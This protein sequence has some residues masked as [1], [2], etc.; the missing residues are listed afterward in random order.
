MMGKSNKIEP[1]L[2][3]HG[4]S[5]ERRIPKD[6]PLRKVKELIDFTFVR[7]DVECLYGKNGNE[8]IDPSVILKLMFLLFYENIKSERALASQLPLRLDWLWFCDYDIDDTTPNHSVIS[9]ARRRWGPDVFAR[10]FENVLFQCIEA[11]LVDGRTIYIDSSTIAA[12]AS[13]EKLRPKFELFGK[14]LYQQLDSQI[15]K[16]PKL[17]A[18]RP[19]TKVTQVDPDAR[20]YTKNG[21]TILGYKEHRVIDDSNGIITAT[22]TTSANLHDDKVFSGAIEE[23]IEN[24]GIKPGKAV[25]DKAYG[26]AANYIYLHDN[27]ILPCI[28]H[29]NFDVNKRGKISRSEFTYN[30]HKDCYICPAGQQLHRYDH[31]KPYRSNSYRYRAKFDICRQCRFADRCVSSKTNGRQVVR[32]IDDEYVE[33]AD[34]CLSKH[35]RRRLL[36]RR[37]YKA[38]G[39]FADASNNHGYKRARWRGIA[40]VQIQNLMIAAVQNIRKLLGY[41]GC[42]GRVEAVRKALS[43]DFSLIPARICLLIG[44]LTIG[45]VNI[46]IFVNSSSFKP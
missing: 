11:G 2:F 7:S 21:K 1:K 41:L 32:N 33:W 37:K 4:L 44:R 45:W 35:E 14:Q 26:F 25:A 8:S 15:D 19:G 28:P 39:S 5:L 17:N 22:I 43:A 20:L 9:K 23:H 42:G 29:R 3:Y 6:H 34:R 46:N 30:H 10:F 24:T 18:D 27:E 13:K 38:E 36:G 31:H 16:Q 40:K 12:N